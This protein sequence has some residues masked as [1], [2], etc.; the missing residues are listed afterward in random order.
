MGKIIYMGRYLGEADAGDILDEGVHCLYNFKPANAC[1]PSGDV[2][3][4][5]FKGT[6]AKYTEDGEEI[7]PID[8]VP[9]LLT[10]KKDDYDLNT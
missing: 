7:N 8:L 5:L 4:D 2:T 6:I 1:V 9:I 3:I 10:A